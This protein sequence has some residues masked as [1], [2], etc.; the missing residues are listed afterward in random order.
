M[1]RMLSPGPGAYEINSNPKA[2][3][4][5]NLNYFFKS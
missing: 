4:D 3:H 5:N 1:S 2:N